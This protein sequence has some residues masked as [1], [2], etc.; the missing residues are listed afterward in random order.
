LNHYK[1]DTVL[2]GGFF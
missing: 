1:T 2:L